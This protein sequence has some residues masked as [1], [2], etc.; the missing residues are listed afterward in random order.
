[1]KSYTCKMCGAKLIINDDENFTNC[2]YCGN[3]IAILNEELKDLN[4]KKII[5]FSI[6]KEEAIEAYTKILRKDII[7]A[8]KVF[9]PVRYCNFDFDYLLYYE[10]RVESTDSDGN[11][12][13]SY[14]DAETLVD[15][16]VTEEFVFGN[17]K[18]NNVCLADEIRRQERLNYDPVLVKDVSIE[19][20]NFDNSEL[21]K[22]GL[23][24]DIRV[25]GRK[26]IRRDISEIYSENYFIYGIDYDPFTTL[27][28]IYIVKTA[29]G[30]IYN[31]PGVK[32]TTALKIS[33]SIRIKR[34][35]A[36]ILLMIFGISFCCFLDKSF[37][38]ND[39]RLYLLSFV[40]LIAGIGLFV[41]S[42]AKK[43]QITES[44]HD[45]YVYTKHDY[46]DHRKNVK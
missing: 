34:F 40:C 38:L 15:G 39:Y 21:I 6:D 29:Q 11:T 19:C 31:Y 26:R 14:Y 5:P 9:I 23:E 42:M 16:K 22:A 20:S 45:N 12:S 10:Y 18:V 1:M 25:F 44:Q 32:P 46:G 24:Q 37:Y 4:I 30:K 2:L 13:T 36:V 43:K 7:D 17:S 8:K 41:S 33:S 27:I 28:P 3:N 35:I